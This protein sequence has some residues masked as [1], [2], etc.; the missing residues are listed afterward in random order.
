MTPKKGGGVPSD[1]S[2]VV[3]APRTGPIKHTSKQRIYRTIHPIP[4]SALNSL[5]Q[6]FVNEPCDF[7][8][9][10]LSPTNLTDFFEY[11]TYVLLFMLGMFICRL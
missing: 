3:G 8:D 2:G 9:P 6:V 10:S 4:S 1:H 5:G 7:L 11:Q